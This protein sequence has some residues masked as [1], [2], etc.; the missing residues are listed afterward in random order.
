MRNEND[1]RGNPFIT[2]GNLRIT[3]VDGKQ[4][5]EKENWSGESVLRI[6]AYK[7]NPEESYAMHRGPEFPVRSHKEACCFIAAISYLLAE[8]M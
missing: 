5:D 3:Y 4:R 1:G 7:G 2:V 8:M 6:Q